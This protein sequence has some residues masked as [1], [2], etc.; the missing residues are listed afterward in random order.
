ML[1]FPC[2]LDSAVVACNIIMIFILLLIT[3]LCE[4]FVRPLD[5]LNVDKNYKVDPEL[6]GVLYNS[7]QLG[8]INFSLLQC[9]SPK[10]QFSMSSSRLFCF[11]LQIICF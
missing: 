5:P 10:T 11:N 1:V 7:I 9:S 3:F 8:H 6:F 4:R 2:R